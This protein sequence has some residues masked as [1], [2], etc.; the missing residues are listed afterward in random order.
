MPAQERLPSM[1][2]L[3]GICKRYVTQSFTQV[4]LDSV[5][6]SFRDNEFVAFIFPWHF[7]VD[8]SVLASLEVPC[9]ELLEFGVAYVVE[10]TAVNDLCAWSTCPK[11]RR[12]PAHSA[13]ARGGK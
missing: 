9:R 7:L 3:K 11:G 6:L 4:A 10:N 1:L 13:P 2:E 8:L 12:R 5:S